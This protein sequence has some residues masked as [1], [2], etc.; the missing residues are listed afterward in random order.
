[1]V[2]IGVNGEAAALDMIS[3]GEMQATIYQDGAGQ[4][5]KAVDL[6][7]EILSGKTV[8]KTYMIDFVLITKDNV[9]DYQ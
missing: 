4:V 7:P 3:K 5:G 8:E 6:I 1:M 9:A 2:C